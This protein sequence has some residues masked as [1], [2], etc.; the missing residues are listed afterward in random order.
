MLA[1]II[2]LNPFHSEFLRTGTLAN[3]E[4]TD[5]MPHSAA[6]HQGLHCLQRIKQIFMIEMHHILESFTYL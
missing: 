3:N 4:D 1:K 2:S 6:F 5:E